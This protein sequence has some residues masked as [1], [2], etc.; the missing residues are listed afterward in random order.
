MQER[1]SLEQAR[2]AIIAALA[3]QRLTV[4]SVS[5]A[6]LAEL[7][8]RTLGETLY[9]PIALPPFAN[10][11]MDG[12]A[13]R[14]ADL[15]DGKL[16][17][18]G[19]M[20]AGAHAMAGASV[21]GVDLA[22][23][24]PKH[25]VRVTTGAA[26]PVGADCVI[27]QEQC[28]IEDQYVRFNCAATP[29]AFV[30]HA[31][32]DFEKG[33]MALRIG[34]RLGAAEIVLV[35]AFGLRT[36]RVYARPRVLVLAGGDELKAAGDKLSHGQ[37]YECNRASLS[38]MIAALGAHVISAPIM[39]DSKLAVASALAS[40]V[41]TADLVISTGGASVGEADFLPNSVREM[42]HVHFYRVR[43]KPG[44]PVLFG[45][46]NGKP[47]LSLP[48]NPVSVFITFLMLAKPAVE[49]LCG[50]E[51]TD[52]APFSLEL[53]E[54]IHKTHAR[55]EF[56]RAVLVRSP[57]GVTQLGVTPPSVKVRALEGQGSAMLRALVQA[58][59]LIDLPEGECELPA[60]TRVAYLA[61]RGLLD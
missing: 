33:Q 36:V 20:L 11:S 47:V 2:V 21:N 15:T 1:L 14:A 31:G 30:R 52:L 12:Y 24:L 17:L 10:S 53:S 7:H 37:I 46:I 22:K 13:L 35:H 55:R 44:M 56:V 6:E 50:R 3:G 45:E 26:L 43:I 29:G 41:R 19:A 59:G 61:F 57:L 18:Q 4:E 54:P 32:E 42:G 38:V 23:L 34:T 48:G 58:D 60:G 39:P 8:G 40:A 51:P 49:M 28:L 16:M 5:T 25:C 27:M 9:A